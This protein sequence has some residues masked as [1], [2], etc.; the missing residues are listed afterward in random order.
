M[1][2]ENTL[3]IIINNSTSDYNIWD[4]FEIFKDLELAER[5]LINLYKTKV[6]II[7]FNYETKV[8]KFNNN[9]Y[10]LTKES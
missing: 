2:H 1:S 10:V 6:D 3:Y 8:Y 5:I 4:C 7:Y 9:K